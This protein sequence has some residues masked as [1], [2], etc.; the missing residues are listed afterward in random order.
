[1]ILIDA[2]LL[3]YAH[4][5]KA[6]QHQRSKE[7]IERTFASGEP[8]GLSWAAVLAFLRITTN[9]R[10]F[11]TPFTLQEAGE[12]VSGWLS[13]PDVSLLQ[14]TERHWNILSNLLTDSQAKG[15]LVM[16]ADLAALAIEHGAVL[17]STDRDFTRFKGL[18]LLNPLEQDSRPEMR[19]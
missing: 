2:N 9:T 8:V 6:I 14:P 12:I 19:R 3:I 11:A 17:C 13:N 10:T 16:D 1:M 18:R 5:D 15:P 4:Y 7:W